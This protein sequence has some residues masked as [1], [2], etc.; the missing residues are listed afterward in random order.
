MEKGGKTFSPHTHRDTKARRNSRGKGLLS[1]GMRSQVKRL[2]SPQPTLIA[3]EELHFALFSL[4][5]CASVVK[6]VL[7]FRQHRP[8]CHRLLPKSASSADFHS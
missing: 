4:C 8:I 5:L 1:Q 2:R 3:T 6:T 7:A